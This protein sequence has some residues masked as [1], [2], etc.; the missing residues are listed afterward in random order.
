MNQSAAKSPLTSGSFQLLLGTLMLVGVF[1]LALS[2]GR[3]RPQSQFPS[4]P[5]FGAYSRVHEM[6]AA[7]IDYLMPIV[8]Y[9]NDRILA[10]RKHLKRIS[11]AMADGGKLSWVDSMWL[12]QLAEQYAVTWNDANLDGVVAKLLRRV[13]IIP[14]AL[15]LVQAA[16]ESS[17]G[18]SRFAVE[19][20]NLFGQWCFR[21]GCGVA[22]ARRPAGAVH[23]VRRF[24]SASESVRSYLRNLNTHDSY[25]HLRRIRQRL[26]EHHQPITATALADGLSFY[27]QRRE[28]YV[29]EIKLMIA[30]Y[31][32]FQDA[33]VE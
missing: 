29:E 17:W 21:Q 10:D 3:S 32:R 18:Q 25:R 30:Q 26:R 22:P 9:Y 16:K 27:S 6:K 23:E 28:A 24:Q 14:V 2:I 5:D 33:R 15:V 8:E 13:D 20:H 4:L 19:A 7:F 12:Q 31:R 11:S 1:A